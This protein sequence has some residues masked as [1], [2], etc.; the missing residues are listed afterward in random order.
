M[1]EQAKGSEQAKIDS[2]LKGDVK[3]SSKSPRRWL[4]VL[5]AAGVI[6]VF[7]FLIFSGIRTRV[8]ARTN[9]AKATEQS[10]VM[11]VSVVHPER[12]A[13][14]NELVLPGSTQAFTDT[15]I[16]ARTNGYLKKWHFDIGAHVKQGQLLAEIDS[17]HI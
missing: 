11:T 10:A 5:L 7:A 12:G 2:T 4:W 1:S 16:Y 6:I 8:Q 13:P 3:H 14:G 9:L 17:P 15:P